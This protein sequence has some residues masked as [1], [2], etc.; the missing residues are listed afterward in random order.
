M[1]A[2]VPEADAEGNRP[3]DAYAAISQARAVLRPTAS[4]AY[5]KP[6]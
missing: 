4:W 1:G 5:R 3:A 2:G 6:S